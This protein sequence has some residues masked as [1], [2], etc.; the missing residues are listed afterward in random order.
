MAQN[1]LLFGFSGFDS[2]KIQKLVEW[3]PK[4]A[5]CSV[6]LMADGILGS[7]TPKP[8]AD[9][10]NAGDASNTASLTPYAPLLAAGVSVQAVTEDLTA[11]GYDLGQ[12]NSGIS[13]VS[14]S[15]L[16]DLIASAGRVISWL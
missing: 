10:G 9:A 7:I 3:A 16:I 13:P 1:L 8:N 5:D 15:N 4:L 11:R 2:S 12:L 6:V 14:Y